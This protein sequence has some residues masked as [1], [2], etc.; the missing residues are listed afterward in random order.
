VRF[1][2][3]TILAVHVAMEKAATVR[4]TFDASG[5]PLL[6]GIRNVKQRTSAE[7]CDV[8][9]SE[10]AATRAHWAVL[11]LATGWQAAIGHR[12][13][14]PDPGDK[15]SGFGRHRL[16]FETPEVVFPR[17]LVDRVYTAVDH[18]MLD[19]SIVFS[20]RRSEVED[21]VADVKR[22]GLGIA[23]IKIAVA[24]Q[25]EVWLARQGEAGLARDIL[26]TDGLSALLLNTEQGDF[27]APRSAVEADQP[28]QSVQRPS[29]V[30]EDIV[31]FVTANAGRPVTFVGPDELCAAVKK[32]VPSAEIIRTPEHPAHDTQ[33]VALA[34]EVR[35]ELNFE[36][37]EVRPALP[38]SWRRLVLGCAAGTL[39]LALLASVNAL[40]A[41]RV[42]Y[43][44]YRLE[45]EAVAR[46]AGTAEDEGA[47][48][49][50]AAELAAASALR[51][52]VARNF[53]AE[54]FCYR[55]LKDIPANAVIDKF[56]VEVKDGQI[57]L[58]FVV[59]GDQVAQLGAHRAIEAGIKDLKY[60]IGGEELP[61]GTGA[62]GRAVQ[63]RMHIIVPDAAEI[64]TS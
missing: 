41:V 21:I 51:G 13:A 52:W 50:I 43:D 15:P 40:Y 55:L 27:T 35:H 14:R 25:L 4:V 38:R 60:K 49:E 1:A 36:L 19:K 48:K 32:Q 31:R 16:M 56:V 39:L 37:K 26:L 10:V 2:N 42:G 47:V 18:P 62:A 54:L 11:V 6:T 63:Y 30:E 7:F 17:A 44:A 46:A 53:H 58:T 3:R 8:L 9:R 59:L 57:T 20:V 12:S 22:C 45:R 29:A 34:P 64:S 24:A 33:N 23:G 61:A 28:R 5:V